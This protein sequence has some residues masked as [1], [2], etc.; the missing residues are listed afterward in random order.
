[1][2]IN[3][4]ED[5][6][7]DAQS[8]DHNW[9]KRPETKYLH[10]TRGEPRNQIQLAFRRHWLTFQ[11]LIGERKGKARC[12]EVGCGRGSLSAYFADDDWDC[13]LLDLSSTAIDQAIK[14]FSENNL[15]GDFQ[16]GNCLNMPFD[17]SSFDIVFSIGLLEHFENLESVIAE[18]HRVLDSDGLFIAY[19][20]PHIPD[21]C[22]RKFEWINEL[23]RKLLPSETSDALSGKSEVYRSDSLSPPYLRILEE[24]NFHDIG[25][26]GIYPLPLI[27][28]SPEFPFSLLPDEAELSL[29]NTFQ[30]WLLS[31]EGN[32]NDPWLCEEGEGQAFIIWGRKS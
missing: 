16:I 27:S 1:M 6:L 18:Q 10:W 8:F 19:V 31:N 25:H 22:Q 21:N 9:K 20:V 11:K 24:L 3:N 14:A 2:M 29:V 12:L 15:K 17:D 32:N 23:L 26:S 13:S 5:P 28:H 7:G 30:E 4:E